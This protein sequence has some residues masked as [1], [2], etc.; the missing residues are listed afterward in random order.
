MLCLGLEPGV[1]GW[2]AQTYP[3]RYGGRPKQEIVIIAQNKRA[4]V[5]HRFP[6]S[7]LGIQC[8]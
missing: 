1:A 3:L 4:K 5:E 8:T 6:N 7:R 2:K